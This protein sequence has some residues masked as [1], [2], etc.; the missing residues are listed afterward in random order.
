MDG[1]KLALHYLYHTN[2]LEEAVWWAV[3]SGGDS[4]SVAAVVGQI[5]GAYYGIPQSFKELYKQ[6]I[7]KFE[8]FAVLI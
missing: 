4:D 2:T 7:E 8:D 6:E 5:G 3:L 1:L